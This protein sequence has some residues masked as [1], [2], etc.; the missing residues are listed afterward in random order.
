MHV[1]L[2]IS[3]PFQGYLRSPLVFS[4]LSFSFVSTFTND[5]LLLV[6]FFG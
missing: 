1:E 4:R 2:L 5:L 6:D 3:L